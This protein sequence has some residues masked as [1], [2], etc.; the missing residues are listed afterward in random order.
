MAKLTLGKTVASVLVSSA[1]ALSVAVGVTVGQA[2]KKPANDPAQN[3][4]GEGNQ[5]NPFENVNVENV[6]KTGNYGLIDEYTITFDDGTVSRFIVI[7]GENGPEAFQAFPNT[8]GHTPTVSLGE[9]GN[10]IINEKDTG[11]VAD[12]TNIFDEYGPY[13]GENGHWWIGDVD[14]GA[15]AQGENGLTPFIGDNGHWWIGEED[16]GVSALGLNGKSAYD[17]AVENGFTGTVDEWLLTLVGNNG[18]S[19]YEIMQEQGYT[20][21]LEEWIES[22]RGQDGQDGKSVY[23]LMQEQGFTGTLQEY[24]DSLVGQDGKSAYEL[25]CDNHEDPD[26]SE[27]EWL[28]SLAGQNGKS[29]YE[30]MQEQ[31]FTGTLQ[32]YLDSLVG[33]DGKSAYDIYCELNEGDD[34][35]EAKWLA[36]LAGAAGNGISSITGP[37]A[38][39]LFDTY[40]INYTNGT[41]SQ[42]VVKNGQDGKD[43]TVTLFGA[44]EPDDAQ[45]VNGDS[46]INTQ[47]WD[48]YVKENDA[49]AQKGNVK[50]ASGSNGKS[51]YEVMQEQGYTGTISEWLESLKGEKGDDG[52]DGKSAFELMQEQGFTGTLQEYLDSLVGQDGKSAYELY[53]DNHDDPDLS[54][55][56]WLDSLAGANGQNGKSAYEIYCDLNADPDLSESD[57][58]AS[59]VGQNGQNGKSIYAAAGEPDANLGNVGDSYV[60]VTNGDY[61]VKED[62]G[63]GTPIGSLKGATGAAGNGIASIELTDDTSATKSVYTVT[64]TDASTDTLEI[65]KPRSIV[66]IVRTSGDGSAGTTDTYTI[67]YNYGDADTFTVTNGSNGN[68][69]LTGD[70]APDNAIGNPGDVYV[71]YVNQDIYLKG[72]TEWSVGISFRG[73]DGRGIANIEKTGPA[74]DGLTY[75][76]TITY[77]DAS[78]PFVFTVTNGAEGADGTKVVTG[79]ELPTVL[80]NFQEG[81]SFINTGNWNYY[82]LQDNAGTLEW[83][84]RGNIRGTGLYTG[85]LGMTGEPVVDPNNKEGD[86]YL[87]LDNWNY[88]VLRDNSGTLEWQLEGNIHN[89]PYE[90]E[91]TFDSNGGSAVAG[92]DDAKEGH[93]ITKPATDPTKEGYFFQGWYTVEGNKWDF[94]KDVVTSDTTLYAHWAQFEVTD[95]VL[96][97]CTATGDVIIPEYFDGQ[98]ISGID[99]DLFK[100]KT[101]ITSISL[102][103]SIREIG[104]SAFEGCSDLESIVITNNVRIIGDNAFK[105]CASLN[106]IYLGDGI[107]EI[108]AHAFNGCAELRNVVVP[109]NVETIGEEAFANCVKLETV[110]ISAPSTDIGD[111]AFVGCSSLRYLTIPSFGSALSYTGFASMYGGTEP[112]DLNYN[113]CEWDL[114]PAGNV[115]VDPAADHS[116]IE[117]TNWD[118]WDLEYND[119][120][121]GKIYICIAYEGVRI[122][123]WNGSEF[124]DYTGEPVVQLPNTRSD[125]YWYIGD[126]RTNYVNGS[127]ANEYYI[128]TGYSDPY[129][130]ETYFSNTNTCYVNEINGYIYFVTTY[131]E[132][133]NLYMCGEDGVLYQKIEGM[134]TE[135]YVVPE[136]VGVG[137]I[138]HQSSGV[139][140]SHSWY[141]DYYLDLATGDVYYYD[142]SDWTLLFNLIDNSKTLSDWFNGTANIPQSL[143]TIAIVGD[144]TMIPKDTFRDCQYVEEIIFSDKV[145]IIG[146]HAFDGCVSLKNINLPSSLKSIGDYAYKGCTAFRDVVIPDTIISIGL[147]AFEDCEGMTSITVPFIGGTASNSSWMSYIFGNDNTYDPSKAPTTLKTITVTSIARVSPHAFYGMSNVETINLPNNL[148][149]YDTSAFEGCTSLKN[150]TEQ[151]AL[152]FVYWGCFKDCASLKSLVLPNTL[153]EIDWNVFQGCSSL[154]SLTLPCLPVIGQDNN[155]KP[156]AAFF[157]Y[158]YTGYTA[159]PSGVP[160]SLKTVVINGGINIFDGWFSGCRRIENISILGG[161]TS[162]GNNAF[163]GCSSLKSIILC[164]TI[165]TIG[166]YAFKDCAGFTSFVIPGTVQNVGSYAFKDCA[167]L[168]YVYIEEGV[169]VLGTF[170]FDGCTGI[171]ALTIP[172]SVTNVGHGLLHG[173]TGIEA[174]VIPSINIDGGTDGRF[175]SYFSENATEIPASLKTVEYTGDT[176]I[177]ANAFTNCAGIETLIISGEPE[178]TGQSAFAGCTTLKNL[179]LSYLGSKPVPPHMHVGDYEPG[180]YVWELVSYYNAKIDPSTHNIITDY[181]W[182]YH[183]AYDNFVYGS[184]PVDDGTVIIFLGSG[185]P[186]VHQ[187]LA[188]AGEGWDDFVSYSGETG[189]AFPTVGDDGYWYFNG[190]KT[191]YRTTCDPSNYRYIVGTGSPASS[192]Y[193]PSPTEQAYIDVSNGNIYF[194]VKNGNDGDVYYSTN[195]EKIYIMVDGDWVEQSESFAG[196]LTGNTTPDDSLGN[197]GDHYLN[198]ATGDIFTKDAGEW[199]V[200]R[201]LLESPSYFGYVFNGTDN[202]NIPA[203]LENLTLTGDSNITNNAFL[204]CDGVKNLIFAGNPTSIGANAFKNY[205]ALETIDLPDSINLIG[206]SAFEGCINLESFSLPRN[207]SYTAILEYTFKDCSS[208]VTM[209]VPK[210][211]DSVGKGAFQGCYSLATCTLNP[212]VTTIGDNAFQDCYSLTSMILSDNVISLGEGVFMNCYSLVT[213]RLPDNSSIYDLPASTFYHCESLSHITLP[214]NISYISAGAF[215]GCYSLRTFN[216]R[217]V[218][219]IYNNAF[220]DCIGLTTL[221]I[222]RYC[223][224]YSNAFEDCVCLTT[225]ILDIKPT[226]YTLNNV[227]YYYYITF[228]ENA[229]K[230]CD[231]VHTLIVHNCANEAAFNTWKNDHVH[232]NGNNP[233]NNASVATPVTIMLILKND[234]F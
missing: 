44:S 234:Q 212:S 34:L 71:D 125:N 124:I 169:K 53:C 120:E 207:A 93:T 227:D 11:I 165:T 39:G 59:L 131:G 203:S 108:G 140:T 129:E 103:N 177:I 175:A 218:Q 161:Q 79:T 157:E 188:D 109:S 35:S 10:W 27:P 172:N 82:V 41:T 191:K 89:S 180:G 160:A 63:W 40:T 20:G 86:S 217:Y 48:Y 198:T 201:Q 118:H 43:G 134:W 90:Y 104:D 213:V 183:D 224:I 15:V 65:A 99:A 36:S 21:S 187:Y 119:G 67:T 113:G 49:W 45:G 112:D 8:A 228:N 190:V 73:E 18:K 136:L 174:F 7:N 173:C 102:P 150:L 38:D 47:T 144:C 167:G 94:S 74:A 162:I 189:Y 210:N 178:T 194:A 205:T 81:D 196:Y 87:N 184:N 58:L 68:T 158:N 84:Y 4:D 159:D 232:A 155:Y 135:L 147:G 151:K 66:S 13:I 60:N 6:E 139:P 9:N 72:L 148:I 75:T 95:G 115:Y 46:Y 97:G 76:Y 223:V 179:V 121:I 70:T 23:E 163:D 137:T 133:G 107:R 29:V 106:Y 222:D 110:S 19:A 176:A 122:V 209:V 181:Y 78:T 54:E 64:Y 116:N 211:V 96:T 231:N 92:I 202:T 142:S 146:A 171:K 130:D 216:S 77:T 127:G 85:H 51:A 219:G 61:Y 91:V 12:T 52:E 214:D 192:Y 57:W 206:K 152:Q 105:D 30:I 143:K 221:T 153:Q 164:D 170:A 88:Y 233:I 100:N 56:E 226:V 14:T 25:Y 28:A 230:G 225:I 220:K 111:N 208:L 185:Y 132:E 17:L 24:L 200:T 199:S 69:I 128:S 145:E 101:G 149:A 138:D 42:F 98:Y 204:N 31:G 80:T 33:A 154:E 16:T 141:A 166:D 114:N 2:Y 117:W 3:G 1:L 22:L 197:D 83:D 168:S 55:Q 62:A 37:V 229:L 186:S 215:M 32:E 26:L 126:T 193:D 156:F 5:T 50:G 195:Y 123:T 182:D